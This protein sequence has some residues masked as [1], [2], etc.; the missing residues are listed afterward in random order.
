MM[1]SLSTN[2]TKVHWINT[3]KL[4]SS[5]S[6]S[7]VTTGNS[8]SNIPSLFFTISHLLFYKETKHNKLFSNVSH[9]VLQIFDTIVKAVV[10]LYSQYFEYIHC[11]FQFSNKKIY[12]KLNQK[13]YALIIEAVFLVPITSAYRIAPTWFIYL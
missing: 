5:S 2:T 13:I 9:V 12:H 1:L 7:S 11:R 8:S 4:V 6:Q 3:A 10:D